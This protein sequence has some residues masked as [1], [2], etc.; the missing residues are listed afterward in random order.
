M[1][2][3]PP[4]PRPAS[5][6][7]AAAPD[8]ADPL[9]V[10][11]AAGRRLRRAAI[12]AGL[13]RTA[14]VA[15]AA[16]LAAAVVDA[17]AG[18]FTA[19]GLTAARWGVLIAAAAA[20]GRWALGPLL[21]P[22]GRDWLA[23]A[24]DRAGGGNDRLFAFFVLPA[25]HPL[26]ARLLRELRIAP[27]APRRRRHAAAALTLGICAAGAAGWFAAAPITARASLSRVAGTAGRPPLRFALGGRFLPLGLSEAPVAAGVEITLRA[28]GPRRRA[29]NGVRWRAAGADPRPAADGAIRVTVADRPAT[30]AA[31][32]PGFRPAVLTLRPVPAPAILRFAVTVTPPD[33]P[34]RTAEN[35][36]AVAATPADRVR[37][38]LTAA[39]PADVRLVLPPNGP[40][41]RRAGAGW[42]LRD[43]PAGDWPVG[44]AL[45]PHDPPLTPRG[46]GGSAGEHARPLFTL[47]V[48][49]DEPP[50]VSLTAPSEGTTVTP[51]GAVPAAATATDDRP[52][53]RVELLVDGVAVASADAAK[54]GRT[55]TVSA[56]VPVPGGVM[57]G[58]SF[59]ISA[60]ATD[61][62]GRR[63]EAAPRA[64]RVVSAEEKRAELEAAAV[65]PA[66]ALNV[67]AATAAELAEQVAAGGTVEPGAVRAAAE[68]LAA[69]FAEPARG[70]GEEAARNGVEPGPRL[71]AAV[72]E[73]GEPFAGIAAAADRLRAALRGGKNA[74]VNETA[75]E[76]AAEIATS[77]E[78]LR[79]AVAAA[80][81]AVALRDLRAAQEELTADTAAA[82]P[83]A[84][85]LPLAAR[86]REIVAAL[87][88]LQADGA[89]SELL[90]EAARSLTAGRRADA[91][92]RQREALAA[93][94]GPASSPGEPS[95]NAPAALK[96]LADRQRAA[97]EAVRG[98]IGAGGRSALRE[99]RRVGG[100]EEEIAAALTAFA[101]SADPATAAA[102]RRSADEAAAVAVGVAERRAAA[103]LFS[104]AD[105]AAARLE[106][107]AAL[108]EQP[109]PDAPP[110][111]GDGGESGEPAADRAAL[112]RWQAFLLDRTVGEGPDLPGLA[113]E[114][115]GLSDL[116]PAGSDLAAQTAA[117][118]DRLAAADPAAAADRQRAALALLEAA[119][120][121]ATAAA[122]PAANPAA[123]LPDPGD[124]ETPAD[125]PAA[126]DPTAA[127]L[128]GGTAGGGGSGG[129]TGGVGF[130]PA[131]E[132]IPWGRLPVRLRERL[133]AAANAAAA[134]GFADLTARYRARL[135][136]AASSSPSSS[137]ADRP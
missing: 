5:N 26:R 45:T 56:A 16:A 122:S 52:G 70:F 93:W 55:A 82:A 31:A 121:T 115:R 50:T 78:R 71:A 60:A 102:A 25:G 10:L 117:A 3:V 29:V 62:A 47:R 92:R 15:V 113:A 9:A 37:V 105:R 41:A 73:A 21:R 67:A 95:E 132:A 72:R 133:T 63:V 44:V 116:T 24:A 38:E 11:E 111:D 6:M 87:A 1:I 65:R 8:P 125:P 103:D 97:A 61:A 34:A 76:F 13:G 14:A 84:D 99:L 35:P 75:G 130:G 49:A 20:F 108:D 36:T 127:G 107:L 100:E 7:P 81:R 33:G 68:R 66:A 94:D 119:A 80:D 128:A 104:P 22:A 12:V 69:E 59:T 129:G 54:K 2:D 28:V 126:A 98:L 23:A 90:R 83:D 18:G 27:P 79:A 120:E 89:P 124:Q 88:P 57:P 17:A 85:P 46:S 51:A 53:V 137:A 39:P 19:D 96:A 136:A 106:A 114:Q 48:A 109:V 101:A 91:V 131:G 43:L 118:A 77:A 135:D 123:T 4:A 74:A 30:F 64:V 58:G 110:A 42:V 32:A 40:R 86:Q 112:A 134:P